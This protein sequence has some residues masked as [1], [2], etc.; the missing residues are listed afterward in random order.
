M[1]GADPSALVDA[2]VAWARPRPW[3]DWV[4]LGGSLGRGAGDALSDV[5]AGLGLAEGEPFDRRRDEVLA[6]ARGFAPVAADLVQAWDSGSSHLIVAY[7]DG[8]QLSL[9][10][11]PADGRTGLPPQTTALLDRSGRFGRNLPPQRWDPDTATLGEWAFLAWIAVGDAARHTAR[12]SSWR[13]LHSLTE[14]RDLLWRLWAAHRGLVF[15]AFG[16]VTV[17]NAG[18]P[19]PPGIERTHPVSLAAADLAAAVRALADLLGRVAAPAPD[20]LVSVVR[21]RVDALPPDGGR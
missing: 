3:I 21:S 18:D 11:A 19:G 14:G 13:A 8:R 20:G 5:D 1:S 9:V 4:N 15:P 2:L 17:Q 12:G 6:G 7:A 10:V 16:V